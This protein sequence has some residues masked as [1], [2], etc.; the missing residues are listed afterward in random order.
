MARISCKV[1]DIGTSLDGASAQ[2][3]SSSFIASLLIVRCAHEIF[4][5]LST[6]NGSIFFRD[7]SV[8]LVESRLRQ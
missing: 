1:V 4:D 7:G 2:V 6:L 5:A 8:A 3:S